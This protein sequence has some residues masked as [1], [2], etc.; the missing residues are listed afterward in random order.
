[1]PFQLVPRCQQELD[2]Q[3]IVLDA[4]IFTTGSS[5]TRWPGM[6]SGNFLVASPDRQQPL[7]AGSQPGESESNGFVCWPLV[8]VLRHSLVVRDDH[9]SK[10]FTLAERPE[11]GDGPNREDWCTSCCIASKFCLQNY[12]AG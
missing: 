11:T 9:G 12:L 1:M 4:A 5:P 7:L 10:T 3:Q 2:F 6:R 8:L